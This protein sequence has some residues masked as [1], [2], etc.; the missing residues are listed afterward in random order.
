MLI[1][2][3]KLLSILLQAFAKYVSTFRPRLAVFSAE[4]TCSDL[5]KST[6][7]AAVRV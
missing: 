7:R 2:G 3:H 6:K 5:T 1:R 4:K